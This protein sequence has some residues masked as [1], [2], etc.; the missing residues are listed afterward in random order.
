MRVA[1]ISDQSGP[2][3]IGG[4]EN[5]L[6][7]FARR[8]AAAGNDVHLFTSCPKDETVD[9][10]RLHRVVGRVNYFPLRGERTGFRSLFKNALY[11]LCLTRFLFGRRFRFDVVDANSI[12][13]LHLPASWLLA[14]WWGARFVITIHEAFASAIDSY[15]AAKRVPFA[16]F[17]ARCA[18]AL[19]FW[20]Q[21]LADELVAASPSCVPGMRREGAIQRVT[22]LSPGE[23]AVSERDINFVT[24][25][26]ALVTTGRLVQMKRIDVLLNAAALLGDPIVSV[27]GTGPLYERLSSTALR[28]GLT[29]VTFYGAADDAT[30]RRVLLNSPIFVLSSYREGWSLATLEAMAHGCLPIFASK[31]SRYETG[32]TSY[33]NPGVNSLQFD[34]TV[35]GLVES[36]RYATA[37]RDR[38]A[39]M[40]RQAWETARQHSWPKA[41]AAAESFYCGVMTR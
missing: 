1:F 8:L 14:K 11:G 22:V 39:I 17:Q 33:A 34:G 28:L 18:K 3:Y 41:V 15:F 4:Y 7:G 24:L 20:T 13:W 40:R 38:L 5:R 9:G 19:Y 12:P 27:I 31:P 30:K 25:P 21:G 2:Y 35:E 23:D 37:D 10:V 16:N 36:V 6:W 26:V 29:N 32:V